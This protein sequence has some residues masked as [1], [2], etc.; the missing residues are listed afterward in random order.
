MGWCRRHRH[1]QAVVLVAKFVARPGSPCFRSVTIVFFTLV[2]RDDHSVKL[3][4]TCKVPVDVVVLSQN[5]IAVIAI[6]RWSNITRQGLE[7][8][9]RL[10][11]EVIAL[12]VEPNEH[13]SGENVSCGNELHQV[14]RESDLAEK[15]LEDFLINRFGRQLYLTFFKSYTEK[16]LGHAVQ[17]DSAEWGRTDQG[18]EPD[19]RG[20]AFS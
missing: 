2:R 11:P 13:W 6:D 1:H 5:P 16:G 4:T 20:E 3:L 19:D 14:A 15:S 8:A 7:F 12:H 9:A 18:L 10:S 17:R